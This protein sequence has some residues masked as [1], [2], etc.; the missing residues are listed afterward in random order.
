M[1]ET[2]LIITYYKILKGREEFI[3]TSKEIVDDN[4]LI[5][6]NYDKESR[7][8]SQLAADNRLIMETANTKYAAAL[9]AAHKELMH[10]LD[11]VN[12]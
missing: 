2:I 1:V 12:N 10:T 8:A 5:A 9:E 6:D 3:M 11:K 7:A 4:Q